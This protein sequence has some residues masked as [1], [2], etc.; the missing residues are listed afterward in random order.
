M[1]IGLIRHG[2]TDWNARGLL[3]GT[4]DIPLNNRGMDQARDVGVLL[5]GAGWDR[6][7]ASPLSRARTTAEIIAEQV[8]LEAPVAMPEFIERSFGEFEGKSYWTPEGGRVNLN[9]ESVET[10]DAVRARA[11]AGIEAI[12]RAHPD[13]STLVVAHGSLIRLLLDLFLVERA[14]HIANVS[15]SIIERVAVPDAPG[16]FARIVTQ[17]NGYPLPPEASSREA[18]APT[19]TEP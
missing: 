13:S 7:A 1:R 19:F 6:I 10:V 18:I 16:T 12:E 8:G 15:L 3:Q 5:R 14:P 17:A 2:E 9:A 4:T 11:L